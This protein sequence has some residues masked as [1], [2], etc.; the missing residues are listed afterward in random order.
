M[1]Q[2]VNE[3][4]ST[5]TLESSENSSVYGDSVTFSTVVIGPG[6]TPTGSVTFYDGSTALDME[7]LDGSGTASFTTTA[8]TAGNHSITAEYSGDD[9]YDADTSNT[10]IQ[11][12]N[13]ADTTT[14][15]TST[16]NPARIGDMIQ[17]S[18]TVTGP[19]TTPTGSITF[20]D[21]IAGALATV[22]LDNTGSATF[23]TNYQD[24]DV[25]SLT[26]D[27]S[28][29]SN[30]NS[31]TSDVLDETINEEP[32][33]TSSANTTF[34]VGSADYYDIATNG[35]PTPTLSVSGTLPSWLTFSDNGDRT[36][37]LY[38]TPPAGSAGTYDFTINAT[39]DVDPDANQ[40]FTLTVQQAPAITSNAS[41]TF[42]PNTGSSFQFTTTGA[43]TA[44]LDEAGALP[45]GVLFVNNGDGTATLSGA[46]TSNDIGSYQI[47]VYATND[48]GSTN[49]AFTLTV[50]G[51]LTNPGDQVN[52]EG[53]QV[54]LQLMTNGGDGSAAT[55][56]HKAYRTV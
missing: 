44:T 21:S 18:A 35:T 25:Y 20:M 14:T 12:V 27:Y 38:G 39:N 15:L 42:L 33:F 40:D 5:S 8:L 43:P 55:Y 34:V 3:A 49:Q 13:M 54:S 45:L 1:N 4:A 6:V 37:E 47:M 29:D 10:V 48:A 19:G 26:A 22:P 24:V 32:V 9:N 28:G 51:F 23:L 52:R 36:A 31:S 7:T 16:P 41:A 56:T 2:T 11:M 53:D 17:Y 46:P 30:Y 50:A